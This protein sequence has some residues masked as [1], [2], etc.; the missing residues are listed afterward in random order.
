MNPRN[1]AAL[2]GAARFRADRGEIDEEYRL[3]RAAFEA[4]ADDRFIVARFHTFLV[5]KLGDYGQAF[6]FAE[7]A[8][9]SNAG[10]GDAWWRRGHVQTQLGEHREALQSY[11]RAA[12][13]MP[14]TAELH[15]HIGSALAEL[16][17]DEEAFAAYGQAVALDPRRP[18]PHLGLAVLHG[19]SRRWS[20]AIQ[21]FETVARLGGGV[22]TSL[23]ELYFESG[24]LAAAAVCATAVLTQDPDNVQMLALMEHV[25]GAVTASITR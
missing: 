13:L 24:R 18:Q 23:C 10:D 11:E 25:R 17:R 3:L 7:A 14:R 16:G 2:L 21:E 9:A 5:D 15:H 19:K 8:V 1:T 20:A 6:A 12:T 4:D 22:P